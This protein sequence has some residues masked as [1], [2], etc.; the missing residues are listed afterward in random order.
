MGLCR[1]GRQAIL[2]RNGGGSSSN[3]HRRSGGGGTATSCWRNPLLVFLL[4]FCLLGSLRFRDRR[5]GTSSNA[6][7]H[8]DSGGNNNNQNKV[9]PLPPPIIRGQRQPP[10]PL[11]PPSPRRRRGGDPKKDEVRGAV[12]MATTGTGSGVAA[13]A[14]TGKNNGAGDVVDDDDDAIYSIEYKVVERG[15]KFGASF[16]KYVAVRVDDPKKPRKNSGDDGGDEQKTVSA[17][18]WAELMT[19]KR[20]ATAAATA[21]AAAAQRFASTI[22]KVPYQAAFFETPPIAST[23][24]AASAAGDRPFEFVLVDAPRLY[25]FADGRPDRGAFAEH[26]DAPGGGCG[27]GDGSDNDDGDDD[28]AGKYSCAFPSLGKDALL[29]APK[30]FDDAAAATKTGEVKEAGGEVDPS[31]YAHLTSF[32][33]HAPSRQVVGTLR[34]AAGEYLRKM[35]ELDAKAKAGAGDAVWFSTSGMGIAWL[36]FRLDSRPKYYT[37]GPYKSMAKAQPVQSQR[38]DHYGEV[39]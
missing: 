21:A 29:I 31:M 14:A 4:T 1:K 32:L 27:N 35:D 6:G 22:E 3:K 37:Y 18:E 28:N 13:A 33:R 2:L 34:H 39:E 12:I 23:A 15:T 36:H 7:N 8:D 9:L 38:G 25:R 26:F 16:T 10:Q 5:G 24:T 30:P 11:L 19:G 17:R 20:I